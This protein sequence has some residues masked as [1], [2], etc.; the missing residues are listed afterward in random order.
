MSKASSSF[1]H[2]T[3]RFSAKS[4]HLVSAKVLATPWLWLLSASLAG[5]VT[6]S[7]GTPTAYFVVTAPSSVTAGSPFAV[8]VTAMAG[9]RRDTSINSWVQF[10][11]SDPEAVL[12]VYHLFTATDAGSYTWPNYTLMTPGSQSITATVIGTP[13]INGTAKVIVIANSK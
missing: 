2:F 8:T 4:A 10:T 11:S 7:C 13:V 6:L 9:G 1:A 12:P 5:F 3:A